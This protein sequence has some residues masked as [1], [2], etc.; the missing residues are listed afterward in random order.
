MTTIRSNPFVI[1]HGI[2]SVVHDF[3]VPVELPS[4]AGLRPAEADARPQLDR[5]LALPNIDEFILAELLPDLVDSAI[6]TPARFRAVL[7]GT[8]SGLRAAAEAKPRAA[9]ALGRAA[10]LLADEVSMRDLLH[11]YQTAL[12]QG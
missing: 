3:H 7:G 4:R 6:L 1:S 10:R 8:L 9:R 11:M 12:L 2:D 5:L